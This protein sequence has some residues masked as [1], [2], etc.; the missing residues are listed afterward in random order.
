MR[1]LFG[2]FCSALADYQMRR[3]GKQLYRWGKFKKEFGGE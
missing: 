3:A 1:K 2:R